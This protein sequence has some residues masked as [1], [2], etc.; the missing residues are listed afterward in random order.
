[1]RVIAGQALGAKASLDTVIPITYLHFT[2]QPT[3]EVVQKIPEGHNAFA[4][5]F[6]GSARFGEGSQ[7]A[8]DGTEGD[9]ALFEK[10]VTDT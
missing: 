7:A 10:D 2:L 8:R 4:Y 9:M 6:R 5:L 1:M 3:A